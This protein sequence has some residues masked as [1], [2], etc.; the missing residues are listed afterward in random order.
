MLINKHVICT[1]VTSDV[2]YDCTACETLNLYNMMTLHVTSMPVLDQGLLSV[3]LSW[4]TSFVLALQTVILARVVIDV[5][6]TQSKLFCEFNLVI[7][8]ILNQ[9][10]YIS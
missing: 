3:T 10:Q 7:F 9:Y 2:I 6:I 8:Y 4:M 1:I 5:F